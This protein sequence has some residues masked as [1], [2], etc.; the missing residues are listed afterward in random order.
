VKQPLDGVEVLADRN[1]SR[2]SPRVVLR[3]HHHTTNRV[4]TTHLKYT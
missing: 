1:H 3:R 4:H 2:F